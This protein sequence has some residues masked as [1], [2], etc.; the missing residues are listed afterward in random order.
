MMSR[1]V[2]P[3]HYDTRSAKSIAATICGVDYYT[4]LGE[5][6]RVFDTE[7]LLAKLKEVGAKNADM[8]RVLDLPSSRIAEMRRETGKRRSI[9]L[10]EAAKLVAHYKLDETPT[11][12]PLTTPVARLVVRHLARSLNTEVDD[13][14]VTRLAEGLRAFSVFA[15]NPRVR[16]KMDAVEGFLQSLE[17]HRQVQEENESSKRQAQD[18]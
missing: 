12:S 10:D 16:D 9:R 6:A 4:R 7:Q 15:A 8:A 17:I 5:T 2:M 3:M 13:N 11:V 1:A 14:E 18:S